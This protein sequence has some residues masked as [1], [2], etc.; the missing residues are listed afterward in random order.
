MVRDV[1]NPVLRL[2]RSVAR[3]LPGRT[4]RDLSETTRA[5]YRDAIERHAVPFFDRKRLGEIRAPE[6]RRYV[7]HLE[8][9]GLA[10]ASVRAMSRDQLAAV[11]SALPDEHR[12]FFELL[13]Q[14]GLRISR[15]SG[16]GSETSEP[17][18]VGPCSRFAAS[19]TEAPS[20]NSR[21]LPDAGT[22]R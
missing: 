5:G 4:A 18:T 10:G 19:A 3:H 12:P 9:Q 14:T 17:S 1:P 2:R 16:S 13:A 7:A 22:C 20:R 6:V 8:D 11:L 21:P 15:R